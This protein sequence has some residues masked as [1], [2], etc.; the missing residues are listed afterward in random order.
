MYFGIIYIPALLPGFD[1]DQTSIHY[2]PYFVCSV[3]LQ[4]LD[5]IRFLKFCTPLSTLYTYISAHICVH[6]ITITL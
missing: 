4:F 6:T 2:I 5:L 1:N 3:S